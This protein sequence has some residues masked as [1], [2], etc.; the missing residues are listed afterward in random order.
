ML[1]RVVENTVHKKLTD[2]FNEPFEHFTLHK[3]NV[4]VKNHHYWI[5]LEISL[6]SNRLAGSCVAWISEVCAL[7]VSGCLMKL[8]IGKLC[9]TRKGLMCLGRHTSVCN[10]VIS[11]YSLIKFSPAYSLITAKFFVNHYLPLVASD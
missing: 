9:Q 10:S 4:S 1:Y 11:A 7:G 5:N 2:L 8:P 3:V 6:K